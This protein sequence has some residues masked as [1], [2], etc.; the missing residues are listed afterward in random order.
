[1]SP[2]LVG[3]VNQHDIRM[4]QQGGRSR[5]ALEAAHRFGVLAEALLADE[6]ERDDALE[7]DDA[8]P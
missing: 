5:L 3:I 4:R 2:E 7:H 8:G 1:M 6:L